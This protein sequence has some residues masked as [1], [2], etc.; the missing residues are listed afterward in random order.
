M[1]PR[2][3]GV[4]V[5]DTDGGTYT[6]LVELAEPATVEVGALGA[7]DL[8]AGWYAYV[9][10]ALGPGGLSRVRRHRELATGERETRH[11]HVDY[12]LSHPATSLDGV[13]A[14]AGTDIECSVAG[15]L[16]AAGLGAVDG[17]GCSDCRCDTHL[18]GAPTR[19]RLRAAV[20][21]AHRHAGEGG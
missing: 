12:L 19:R 9:G 2:A 20:M 17:F 5:T 4:G 21:R 13:V 18:A 16:S 11:W 3:V 8:A 6:L 7:V 1:S 10:S 15:G 14:S